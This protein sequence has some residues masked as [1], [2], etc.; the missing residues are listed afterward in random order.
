M[1]FGR[2][3]GGFIWR[4][5]V[6]PYDQLILEIGIFRQGELRSVLECW[7]EGKSSIAKEF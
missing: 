2:E 3:L 7:E 6:I 5:E 4:R 1:L